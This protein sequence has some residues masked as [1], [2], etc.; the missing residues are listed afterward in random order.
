[1]AAGGTSGFWRTLRIFILILT[2]PL[3]REGTAVVLWLV[4]V[5]LPPG[6]LASTSTVAMSSTVSSVLA[7]RARGDRLLVVLPLK[8]SSTASTAGSTSSLGRN[9]SLSSHLSCI[10]VCRV[11]YVAK[12][13]EG[14]DRIFFSKKNK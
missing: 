12:V 6:V 8:P 10:T 13:V 14:M 7:T 2:L 4:E 9:G 3:D 5:E 1:M 11:L